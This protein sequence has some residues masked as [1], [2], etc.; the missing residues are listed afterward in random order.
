MPDPTVSYR[1]VN[2]AQLRIFECPGE[3]PTLFFAHATSFHAR[4]WDQVISHLPGRHAIAFD[5][6]GHGA[7][8]NP[9][10]PL[11]W[12]DWGEDAAELTRQLDLRGA[13]AIGHSMGGHS[14]TIA[15]ALEPQRFAGLLLVD[16]VIQ[17]PEDYGPAEELGRDSASRRDEWAS[18]DEMFESYLGRGP[19]ASWDKQVLHDYCDHGLVPAPDGAE[20]FVLGCP[21]EVE[22]ALYAAASS[23]DIYDEIATI[24]VPVRILRAQQPGPDGKRFISSPTAPDLSSKF[25][26]AQDVYLPDATHFIPMESPSLVAEHLGEL[27]SGL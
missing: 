3:S 4:C 2:G 16:P 11:D 25:R 27:I 10:P 12:R 17:R 9:Y 15:A 7:S 1:E 18:P 22:A 21:P 26:N 5:M 14:V 20:G 8:D 19:F 23:T 13:I 6:R 24:E